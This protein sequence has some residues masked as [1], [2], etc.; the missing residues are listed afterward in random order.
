MSLVKSVRF[1]TF[2]TETEADFEA[3]R[4]KDIGNELFNAREYED[5]LHHYNLS[6]GCKPLAP[7]YTNRAITNIRLKRYRSALR[8][9]DEALK[10]DPDNLKAHLRMAQ[11]YEGLE[12]YDEAFGFGEKSVMIDPN[13]AVAQEL[14]YRMGSKLIGTWKNRNLKLIDL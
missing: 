5:A 4:Q 13:N 3:S 7:V 6:L 10:L 2:A 1:K 11:A 8:D 9:C 12:M 14:A